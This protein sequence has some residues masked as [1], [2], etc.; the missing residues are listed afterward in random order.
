M[1]HIGFGGTN[2]HVILESYVS[3]SEIK[4]NPRLN[5]APFTP[6][7]F[8][9][10]SELSLV[11]QLKAF[12]DYLKSKQS[13]VPLDNLLWTLQSRRSV[14]PFKVAFSGTSLERLASKIDAK[15]EETAEQG[16][17]PICTRSNSGEIGLLG[18]FTGQGAQWAGMGAELIQS[19][20]FVAARIKEL[21]SSLATLPEGDRPAWGIGDALCADSSTSRL[22]EAAIAQP[23]S[24]AIQIVLVDLLR[25]AGVEFAAVVGHSSG[26]IAAAYAAGFITGHD[27]IRISYYRGMHAKLAGGSEG[28]RG[29]MIAVGASLEE[30]QALCETPELRD[31]LY[32]GAYNSS[33]SVTLSGDENGI[34]KAKQLFL[35]KKMFVRQLKVDTAYHS[36]HMKR[37]GEAYMESIRQIN[38]EVIT[39][40]ERKI[41]W[42]ST[43]FPGRIMEPG[44]DLRA[45]YWRDNMLKPVMFAPALMEAARLDVN[46][47]IE[48]GPHPAL[49]A[50]GKNKNKLS[51][52][53]LLSEAYK[54]QQLR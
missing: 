27:A 26:E 50:P 7:T 11:A 44:E 42:Y 13:A 23:L 8:S 22:N 35:D 19:S 32:V 34:Q 29:T 36:T 9:A 38:V 5:A 37:P 49:K 6:F 4:V 30:A 47:A 24:T 28:Q 21:E 20:C 31:R 45:E 12:S 41:P 14:F 51:F 17:G 10:A 53:I 18:I 3:D 39:D 40:R 54:L 15:L 1:P 25:A 2:A 46:V 52:L 33:T 43:V 16:G 48:I